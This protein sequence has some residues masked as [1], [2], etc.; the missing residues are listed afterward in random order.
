[1]GTVILTATPESV[2]NAAEFASV[3]TD[4]RQ[5]EKPRLNMRLPLPRGEPPIP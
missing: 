4:A 5:C 3:R 1:M 2:A